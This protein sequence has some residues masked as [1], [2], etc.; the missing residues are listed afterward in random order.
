MGYNTVAFVLNDH[1]HELEKS[2]KTVA[3]MLSHAPL[4]GDRE[5]DYMSRQV[6]SVAEEFQEPVPHPQALEIM[7]TFHADQIRYYRAGGNCM[8]PLDLAGYRK[9]QGRDAVVLY[10]PAWAVRK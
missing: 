9:H 10:L 1:A 3:W 8:A 2:P 7:P 6:R 5:R 4:S